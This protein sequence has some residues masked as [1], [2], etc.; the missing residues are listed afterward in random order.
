[1]K[2]L[3]IGV[4]LAIGFGTTL[5]LL[6]LSGSVSYHYI[7]QNLDSFVDY[8]GL[9]RQTNLMGRVQANLLMARY[10]VKDY[11]VTHNPEKKSQFDSYMK[12]TKG[13]LDEAL[14]IVDN[15]ERSQILH[16]TH[17]LLEQYQQH[18]AELVD[19]L[20]E[21][22]EQ[23]N[24]LN[25][26]GPQIESLLTSVMTEANDTD[27]L[28]AAF[29]TGRAMRNLLLARLYTV[30]YMASHAQPDLDRAH[31]EF[32]AFIGEYN[33]LSQEITRPERLRELKQAE[34]LKEKYLTTLQK[35]DE[36]I[37]QSDADLHE[38]LDK[39]GPVIAQNIDDAKLSVK[40]DQDKLGPLVQ[41]QSEKAKTL[42][43]IL[44]ALAV[45][46]GLIAGIFITRAIAR[47]LAKATDFAHA[48]ALGDFTRTISVDQRDE[49]G[50]I[51]VA[52][53]SIKDAVSNATDE[54]ED[55]VA[56]VEQGAIRTKGE[57]DQ[58]K[59]GFANL[60]DGV[61]TLVSTFTRFIDQIPVGVMTVSTSLDIKYLNTAAQKI[62]GVSS[63]EGKK[64]TDIFT[65][66]NSIL[67]QC[68]KK[69]ETVQ[70]DT[71]AKT[72][73]GE[74]EIHASAAPL[75]TRSGELAGAMELIIDQTK[76]KNAQRIM[77][78][79]ANQANDIADRVASAS[80][81][82][83]AQV[84]Q[85]SRGAETQQERVG[86]TVTAMEEMN[87]TV[88]EVA[89]N[90]SRA[91]EQSGNAKEKADEGAEL[92]S[93]VVQAIGQMNTV[94][95]D[96]HQ[97][98]QTLGE[99][100]E[101]IGG[102]MTVITDIADQTNLLA[103]N[104]AIEAARAGDAGRGFAVVADEVR[105][106][107][108]KTMSATREVGENIKAIQ[109]A[110]ETNMKSVDGAVESVSQATKL[111]DLSGKAL[112]AIVSMSADSSELISS[113]ATAAEQQSAT[114][115]EINRAIEDVNR[116]V[117]ETTDGMLQSSMA[118]QELA[119]MS[120]DLKNVLDKLSKS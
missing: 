34:H 90:A 79:V 57:V 8:R 58:Y 62:A 1:M 6:L 24:T 89:R 9:A 59:G 107:A 102:V 37:K 45:L 60:V 28:S 116:I 14:E 100:A 53:R 83:S 120:L 114:S 49:V 96:L 82:L 115:E 84:E 29:H 23:I 22:R 39:L 88:L 32:D 118:V 16:E 44:S 46:F 40:A 18:F 105:K 17:D 38:N 66:K 51:C 19:L 35:V 67:S 68:L 111:A 109:A 86:E 47:P 93:D 69:K 71:T 27:N 13:L 94:A 91:A 3:S 50:K 64:V 75:L 74:Y 78:D 42:V 106:L 119:K 63:Y 99:Q 110:T 80:E 103:L 112:E 52:L 41:S 10:D 5:L 31:T 92:V 73:S 85:V 43:G 12:A 33:R 56:K 97:N 15:P 20:S 26:T 4:K 117:I 81:E 70:A 2:N 7:S 11:V 36:L 113:I 21:L 104:A 108:E 72:A 76:I 61:N 25:T 54:V 98:M 65:T 95:H 55:I 87:A 77:V 48:V 101:A 30:K